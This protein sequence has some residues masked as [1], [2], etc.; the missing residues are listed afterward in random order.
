MSPLIRNT[1]LARE[2]S[3]RCFNPRMLS[4]DPQIGQEEVCVTQITCSFK[5][6]RCIWLPM[7]RTNFRQR[8]SR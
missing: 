5:A 1:S 7:Y 3:P 8:Y 4:Q 6:K 2:R